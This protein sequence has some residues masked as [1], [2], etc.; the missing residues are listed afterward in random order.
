MEL[1]LPG[2][3]LKNIRGEA[4]KLLTSEHTTAL[5]LS[6]TLGKMN[7][8]TKAIAIAP[9]FYRQLHVQV[10]PG[11]QHPTQSVDGSERGVTVVAHPLHP[12]EWAE[13]DC[14]KA[15]R[16]AGNGCL[17]NGLGHSMPGRQDRG[18][19]GRRGEET[20]H[21]L[22]RIYGSVSGLQMLLQGEKEHPC[23]TEDGQHIGS[24]LHQQDGRDGVP[25]P[26][27]PEQAIL[28]MVHGEGHLCTSTAFS[29]ET[30]QHRG[31]GIQRDERQIRLETLPPSFPVHQ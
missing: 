5:E 2:D 11:L 4:K 29:R 24:R 22:P 9:L 10:R 13:S 18:S 20:T 1:R 14:E 7:A 17:T 27:Q 12:V 30:E 23:P 6:R 21:Q 3:K 31:C 16:V 26:K 8:A 19:L 28:A 25:S 15:E